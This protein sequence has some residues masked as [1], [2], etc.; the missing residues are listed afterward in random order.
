MRVVRAAHHFFKLLKNILMLGLKTFRTMK[1]SSRVVAR[2]K[3]GGLSLFFLPGA[4]DMSG[5]LALSPPPR[6]RVRK[7]TLHRLAAPPI[8]TAFCLCVVI[9]FCV[10]F[11]SR[12][13]FRGIISSGQSSDEVLT[14]R[15]R[16]RR[17]HQQQMQHLSQRI[18]RR[19]RRY[20]GVPTKEPTLLLPGRRLP[21]SKE[22]WSGASVVA[23]PPAS[24]SSSS[25]HSSSH[26]HE[27][28][29]E[30]EVAA[31]DHKHFGVCGG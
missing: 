3:E 19:I 31:R 8:R 27:R 7:K 24:S 18:Y 28:N 2:N 25:S 12:K 15:L 10:C 29:V 23:E 13:G 4:T 14:Y 17:R 11:F 16:R 5:Y 6:P 9:A 21:P 30:A 26:R 1:K 22:P 20:V